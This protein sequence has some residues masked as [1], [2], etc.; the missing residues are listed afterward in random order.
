MKK[1]LAPGQAK[2]RINP[3][4]VFVNDHQRDEI[5]QQ[6]KAAGMTVSSFVYTATISRQA[7]RSVVDLQAVATM[8][9][10]ARQQTQLAKLLHEHGTPDARQ[11]IRQIAMVQA[12]LV[13]AARKITT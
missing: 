4:R 13:G 2:D 1:R 9:A 8:A 10:L 5:K 11:I 6:A 7:V 3:I 12:S